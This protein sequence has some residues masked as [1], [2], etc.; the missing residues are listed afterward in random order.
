[1]QAK[2]RL[3]LARPITD[4][5]RVRSAVYVEGQVANSAKIRSA[6]NPN[7]RADYIIQMVA[8]CKHTMA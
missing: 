7:S 1:M 3:A 5:G 8:N 2:S 6:G 4:E